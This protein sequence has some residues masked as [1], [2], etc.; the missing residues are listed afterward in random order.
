MD[1]MSGRAALPAAAQVRADATQVA[2]WLLACCALLFAMVVVGGVTRLTHSGLS[3]VEWKPIIGTVPPLDD[4]QWQEA[5]TKYRATPESRMIN[6]DMTLAGFKGIYWWEY[7]HRLLGRG[8]GI[9][10]LVPLAWFA[11]RRRIDRHLGRRL[12]LVFGLGLVQGGVGWWMVQSGLV[13]DPRVSAIR[14]TTHLGIA[15]LL[16]AAMF[17][18]ALDLLARRADGRVPEQR[19]PLA[20]AAAAI[21]ALVF[22]MILSGGLVAGNRAG[23]V[24]NTFPLMDGHWIPPGLFGTDPWYAS[25][26][27]DLT[28]VQFDHRALAWLLAL[29]IPAFWWRVRRSDAG[30]GAK[31]AAHT[32]LGALILQVTLGIATLLL[33]VSVPVAAAHQAGAVV[34]LTSALWVAHRL[35][36]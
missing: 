24:Y 2:T 34:L 3:I 8:I 29:L 31:L 20:R 9:A 5:F 26:A 4:A 1:A 25:F 36:G 27:R 33:V 14:L 11:L 23:L 22:L 18:T 15:L 21:A 6:R 28:T 13:D 7:F 19:R 32:L 12:G 35:R 17:W 10:F 30:D 16:Y